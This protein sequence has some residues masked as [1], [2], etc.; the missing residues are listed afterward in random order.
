M[1][2]SIIFPHTPSAKW[3]GSVTKQYVWVSH[4]CLTWPDQVQRTSN[5]LLP[6]D[7][8]QRLG[9]TLSE[10]LE[11]LG[12]HC[13]SV[14]SGDAAIAFLAHHTV[15]LVLLDIL[16]PD[17]DGSVLFRHIRENHPGLPVIFLSAVDKFSVAVDQLRDGASDFLS[18][19]VTL[20]ELGRSID[21]ALE[22]PSVVHRPTPAAPQERSPKSYEDIRTPLHLF[23]LSRP[24][25]FN[26]FAFVIIL[27]TLA[28]AV[29]VASTAITLE[30]DHT[31]VLVL[32]SVPPFI[33]LIV[34]LL[35][36]RSSIWLLPPNIHHSRRLL[37]A[38]AAAYMPY[39]VG[40]IGGASL[41]V[42]SAAIL[43]L[44]INPITWEV[45]ASILSLSLI[46]WLLVAVLANHLQYMSDRQQENR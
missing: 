28:T 38:I 13:N 32:S 8:D 31:K 16:M 40:S 15:D 27:V 30:A 11:L 12:Y 23:F 35:L 1:V 14:S 21:R 25:A 9:E 29:T 19:P 18:K 39:A 34:G 37:L 7:D 4:A 36:T 22:H 20:S 24:A 44:D 33:A 5:H 10:G 45:S 43:P 6:V 26:F 17:M 3:N 42:M 46:I 2:N 41:A